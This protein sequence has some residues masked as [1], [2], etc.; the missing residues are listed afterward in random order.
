MLLS[1]WFRLDL[2]NMEVDINLMLEMFLF[3]HEH[4]LL[5]ITNHKG[6]L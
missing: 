6:K 2:P 5:H 3:E 4:D 1:E